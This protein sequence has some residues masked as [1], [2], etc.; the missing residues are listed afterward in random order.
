MIASHSY[1]SCHLMLAISWFNTYQRATGVRSG[2]CW[3]S[4]STLSLSR[5]Q[6]QFDFIWLLWDC[7]GSSHQEPSTKFSLVGL[8]KVI[9]SYL[10][11]VHCDHKGMDIV[12]APGLGR[13]EPA[14]LQANS[15]VTTPTDDWLSGNP[16][17]PS[18][19]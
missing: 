3:G 9:I 18:C 16:C 19:M 10:K 7:A 5:L 2:D 11:I 8:I 6:N 14:F 12:M 15:T 4:F 13:S 17:Q 1:C